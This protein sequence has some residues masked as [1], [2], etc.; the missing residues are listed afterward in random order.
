MHT[1]QALK[2]IG[3]AVLLADGGFSGNSL[4]EACKGADA[5]DRQMVCCVVRA[6]LQ[7]RG[8]HH[9]TP[10]EAVQVVR[11]LAWM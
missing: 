10:Q 2:L 3:R 7:L 11:C 5:A 9:A 8:I 4:E 1:I 6:E